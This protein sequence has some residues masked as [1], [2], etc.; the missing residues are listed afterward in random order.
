[1]NYQDLYDGVRSV[2]KIRQDNDVTNGKS[3]TYVKNK[4]EM[5]WLIEP[6]II[7]DKNQLG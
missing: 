1:M 3:A 4:T 5:L 2:M 6:D 7:W